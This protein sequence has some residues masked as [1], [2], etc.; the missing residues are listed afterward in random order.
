MILLLENFGTKE[1][2]LH[3]ETYSSKGTLGFSCKIERQKTGSSINNLL[4]ESTIDR[5]TRLENNDCQR[6]SVG[7][8]KI[9]HLNLL[10]VS[11]LL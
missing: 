2:R 11:M 6:S 9:M 7:Q 8:V 10:N 3:E 4:T 5:E 1:N